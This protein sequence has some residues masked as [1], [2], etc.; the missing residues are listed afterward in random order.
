[1]GA[2]L[3][4]IPGFLATVLSEDL[5][6]SRGKIGL[7][8]G[9]YFGATGIG[10]IPAGRFTDK[11]GARKIATINM[12]LVAGSSLLIA[13][14]NSYAIW[15]IGSVVGGMGY[16]LGNTSTNV[17]IGHAVPI[18]RRAMA[19]SVKTS[20]VPLMATIAAATAPWA[21]NV[22]SWQRVVVFNAI[23]AA[24]TGLFTYI[25][26]DDNRSESTTGAAPTPLPKDFYWFG[27]AAFLLIGGSQ[28]LYSWTVSYLEESL[29]APASLSGGI[30]AIA[31]FT[32]V[33]VMIC[34]GIW[35]DRLGALKRIPLVMLL[36]SISALSVG[37]VILGTVIGTFIVVIGL[38]LGVSTQLAAIGTMHAAV[39]DKAPK[40]VGRATGITMTGYYLGA[41]VTPAGFGLLVDISD[42][43]IYSW[44]ATLAILITAV[45]AWY[46]AGKVQAQRH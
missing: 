4:F 32:G 34:N 29:D 13:I 45:G 24:I 31:S 46:R 27:I 28:P 21:A 19:M 25:V 30:M 6:I 3:G 38:T 5:D 16:A 8:V 26:L 39:I 33:I 1:M 22:W 35:A 18:E 7:I 10:S 2:S 36:L 23:V 43:Y 37:L 11:F 41:L 44:L 9:I 20:G 40:S 42:T 12:L 14:F 17:A 15:I